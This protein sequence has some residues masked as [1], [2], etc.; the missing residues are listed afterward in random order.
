MISVV[1]IIYEKYYWDKSNFTDIKSANFYLYFSLDM[2]LNT[3]T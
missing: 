3:E 2:Y 1:I